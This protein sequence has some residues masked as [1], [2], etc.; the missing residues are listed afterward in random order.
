VTGKYT[1][2]Q[3]IR[4]PGMLHG[5]IV[6]PRGQGAY[7]DGTNPQLLSVDASSIAHIPGAKV[8]RKGNFL[9]VV[10]VKEYDAIQAAA[11]LK[12]KWAA[13][14]ELPS[15]GNVFGAMRKQDSAGLVKAA[16]AVNIG[17]VD[18]AL[19]SAAHVVTAT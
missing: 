6:R 13:M 3:S 18:G 4:I 12:A 10:A 5:R 8:V 19:A 17:N 2:V 1:Y 11:L 7:G 15:S 14:P 9:G 16:T